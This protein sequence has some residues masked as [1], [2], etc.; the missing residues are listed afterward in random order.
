MQ[1]GE[2]STTEA[3]ALFLTAESPSENKVTITTAAVHASSPSSMQDYHST[4]H[5]SF[6]PVV[7]ELI[8]QFLLSFAN[9]SR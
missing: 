8:T 1:E 2:A 7:M 9:T 5:I 3:P 6:V 4:R